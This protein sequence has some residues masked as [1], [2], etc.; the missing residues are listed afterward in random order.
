VD[1]D[2]LVINDETNNEEDIL[3]GDFNNDNENFPKLNCFDFLFIGIYN[4]KCCCKLN[5]K[6]LIE[7][8]YEIISKYYSI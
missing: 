5:I 8:S 7:K 6:K 2:I 1:K 3:N 4:G